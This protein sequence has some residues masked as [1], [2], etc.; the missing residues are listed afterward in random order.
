MK[1]TKDKKAITITITNNIYS[2]IEQKFINKSK[3]INWLIYQDLL[4]KTNNEEL[5]KIII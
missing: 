5:K 2:I 3:Y 4:N 1:K